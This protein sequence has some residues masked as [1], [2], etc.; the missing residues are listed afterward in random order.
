MHCAMHGAMHSAMHCPISRADLRLPSPLNLLPQH[1]P[2]TFSQELSI[3]G[4]DLGDEGVKVLC[5]ALKERQG[6]ALTRGQ[7]LSLSLLLPPARGAELR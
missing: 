3:K 5:E 4:N 7:A 6:G 1:P 2:S